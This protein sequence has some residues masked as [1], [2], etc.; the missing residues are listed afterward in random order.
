MNHFTPCKDWLG[1]SYYPILTN[2]NTHT[3]C[4]DW[5]GVTCDLST[6]D[7]I[8]IDVSCGML[9]GIIHANTSLFNLPRL[10]K[11]NL[12]YN[13][14]AG[15]QLPHEIGRFSNSL[16]HFNVSFCLFFGQIPG[17]IAL[18]LKLVS[19]DMSVNQFTLEYHVFNN[20]LRNATNLEE[21]SLINV[22]IS[23]VLPDSLNIS[24]SLKFLNL[25]N[26]GLQGK[27]PHYIFNLHSLEKLDL[28]YNSFTGDIPLEISLLPKLVFL[29][30]S[31][32]GIDNLRI[33]PHVFENLLKNST[34]LRDIS[35]Y[36]VNIGSV[37]PTYVNVSSLKS[38]DLRRTNLQGNLPDNIFNLRYLELLNLS[39]NNL[40][41][42]LPS[43]LFTLPYVQAIRLNGNKFSGD[44]PF[45]L[46]DLPSLKW[47][48][49]SRNQL[50]GLIDVNIFGKLPS[51]TYLDLSLN[52][53]SGSLELDKFFSS[54]TNLE[55]LDLSYNGFSV[56][57]KN[58][59]HYVNPGF[60]ILKLASCKLKTF[61]ESLRLMQNLVV[62]NLASNEIKG[63]ILQWVVE[64]N[65]IEGPF[66]PSICNM[67][68]LLYLD[69]SNNSFG[70]LIPECAGNI[71]SLFV[72]MNLANNQF[73]GTIPNVHED[74]RYL[75]G[76]ILNG[77]QLE[78][79]V[80]SSF[81]KCQSL[82]VVDLGNN[83]LNGTF[84]EWLG[85]L[86][87]LQVLVLK[88]NKLRGIIRTSSSVKFSFPSL[89]VL[90]LSH[91]GFFGQL[92][93]RY[94]Q[95]SNGLKNMVKSNTKPEYLLLGSSYYSFVI[96]VKGVD[97]Y[98]AQL[99]VEYT[100]LDLSENNFER[101]IPDI[102][103]KLNSLKVL[104]LSHNSLTGRIPNSLGRISEVESL[105]LSWNQLTRQIHQSLADIKGLGVL[106]ISQN[107]LIGRIPEGTQFN[108]FDESSFARNSGLCGFP[109]PKKCS[110]R[111][112]KPQL[113]EHENLEEKNR[114]TWE[115]V[116]LG[117]GCGTLLGLVTGYLMLSTRKVKWFN[118]IADAGE[119]FILQRNKRKYVF[120]G[121]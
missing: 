63:Q 5:N 67:S 116:T 64:S 48:I 120:I 82:R 78:G 51:L 121:R 9:Q 55:Y 68:S 111:T 115:V 88:S 1:S 105:D 66:P 95:Y 101:E 27:L 59:N 80:P 58:A 70:G 41:G 15:S 17:N 12:A 18:F 91:N 22:N 49:L 31:S 92:P 7:V 117:Y 71:N 52:N 79:E 119:H 102:I 36:Q 87:N 98:F 42:P 85:E 30:L 26:T 94:F 33:L 75:E 47:L 108:T 14:F 89:R 81:S 24:S 72:M 107:R 6:S 84:P 3:D 62:L 16:T 86:P 11:L 69:M 83:H 113:E 50:A 28:S 20:L 19:F 38:L 106:N 4:C 46:F 39:E 2:W 76:L 93:I 43:T 65:L 37:L 8:D 32:N 34:L 56:T 10:Q 21:L 44:V 112:H 45:H 60:K 99:W 13:F 35:L 25:S 97:Q 100:I 40:T 53:F 61:P 90:D 118:A 54:L 110:E 29:D 77:N 74:C 73:Q 57:T 23:L 103:G 104:N 114:F 109:L 96:A